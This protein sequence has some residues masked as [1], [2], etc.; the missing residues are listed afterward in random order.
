MSS[1]LF[2]K[3]CTVSYSWILTLS[4]VRS[5]NRIFL[6]SYRK[7]SLFPL[8]MKWGRIKS[9]GVNEHNLRGVGSS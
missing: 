6:S 8:V 9:S 3:H 4:L 2:N 1:K 7:A 5:W